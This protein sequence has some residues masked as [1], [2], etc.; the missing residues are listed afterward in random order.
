MLLLSCA[1]VHHAAVMK[2]YRR[3]ATVMLLCAILPSLP[4]VEYDEDGQANYDDA[5]G[6]TAR[7]V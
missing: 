7:M 2:I 1:G 6:N 5:V 4:S 3:V